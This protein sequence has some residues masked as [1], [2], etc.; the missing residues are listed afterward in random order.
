RSSSLPSMRF[1]LKSS[2]YAGSAALGWAGAVGWAGAGAAPQPPV[3]AAPA[4]RPAAMTGVAYMSGQ[5]RQPIGDT[6]CVAVETP[7]RGVGGGAGGGAGRPGGG[8]RLGGPVGG[9]GGGGG[10]RRGWGDQGV[11]SARRPARV[12]R[13]AISSF[14][15]AARSGSIRRGT[16]T[17]NMEPRPT[18]L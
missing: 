2:A 14:I 1:I 6:P 12:P 5:S 7:G 10:G 15:S 3:N 18:S 9:G 11:A 13:N 8:V 16:M 4:I 17:L